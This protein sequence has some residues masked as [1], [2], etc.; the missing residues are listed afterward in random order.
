MP[1]RR[2]IAAVS[3][4]KRQLVIEIEPG[5]GPLSGCIRD[6]AGVRHSF[7]GW[8]GFASALGLALGNDDGAEA[9]P[10]PGRAS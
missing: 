1:P 2:T 6:E 5:P 3:E 8:L 7:A 10:T 4:G 9:E